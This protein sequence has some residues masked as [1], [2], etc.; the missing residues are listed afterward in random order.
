MNLSFSSS[1]SLHRQV[2]DAKRAS[3]RPVLNEKEASTVSKR[4]SS[5]KRIAVLGGGLV[6]LTGVYMLAQ[7]FHDFLFG[8]SRPSNPPSVPPTPVVPKVVEKAPVPEKSVVQKVTKSVKDRLNTGRKQLDKKIGEGKENVLVLYRSATNHLENFLQHGLKDF[9]NGM[10]IATEG[11]SSAIVCVA[12]NVVQKPFDAG[13]NRQDRAF[14]WL[15]KW[16]LRFHDATFKPASAQL[17]KINASS[18]PVEVMDPDPP[19]KPKGD[20]GQG[21]DTVDVEFEKIPKVEGEVVKP[22]PVRRITNRIQESVKAGSKRERDFFD[23]L[24]AFWN[25]IGYNPLTGKWENSLEVS[26][27]DS[28]HPM[29]KLLRGFMKTFVKN[30]KRKWPFGFKIFKP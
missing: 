30:E 5:T 1:Y 21:V 8:K 19:P 4:L 13:M 6:G 15:E 18:V 20:L 17:A 3:A 2:E 22:H 7:K 23:R 9:Q 12:Q 28:M 27:K 14:T 24:A 26:A 25:K 10:N 29:E 16:L 11:T